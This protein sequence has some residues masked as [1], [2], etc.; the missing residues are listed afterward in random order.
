MKINNQRKRN[1]K[2]KHIIVV[3]ALVFVLGGYLGLAKFNSWYPFGKQSS[4]SA[5]SS[6]DISK[7]DYNPAT[8]DQIKAGEEAKKSFSDRVTEATVEREAA[9]G[10]TTPTPSEA[11]NVDVLI[12]SSNYSG[13]I[14]SIRT[15]ISTIDANGSC[16][17]SLSKAGESTVTRTAPTQ[18]MGSYTTC[19][20]FDIE[21]LNAG[22]WQVSVKYN[23]SQNR[24]GSYKKEVAI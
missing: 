10:Q 11:Q 16:T 3:I 20:G 24:T 15:M 1:Y 2:K 21:G 23:G 19:Q 14:L 13:G 12:T 22:K 5:D 18:T 9:T 4:S 7:I 6:D 8:D 17:L